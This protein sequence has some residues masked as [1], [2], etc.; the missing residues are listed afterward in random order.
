[1]SLDRSLLFILNVTMFVRLIH[2][3]APVCEMLA[4]ASALQMMR[5]HPKAVRASASSLA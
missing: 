3:P 1:M 4:I 2:A 5:L